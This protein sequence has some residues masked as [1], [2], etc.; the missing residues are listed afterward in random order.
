MDSVVVLLMDIHWMYSSL[1]SASDFLVEAE[2]SIELKT[3]YPLRCSS[4]VKR[5]FVLDYMTLMNLSLSY[6]SSYGWI[7][8]STSLRVLVALR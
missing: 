3:R 7:F 6:E 5:V 2:S 8:A 4:T 1:I